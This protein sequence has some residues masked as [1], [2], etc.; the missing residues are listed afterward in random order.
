[1]L[2]R[3]GIDIGIEPDVI[4]PKRRSFHSPLTAFCLTIHKSYTQGLRSLDMYLP[5]SLGGIVVVVVVLMLLGV[6]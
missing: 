4:Q 2:Q 6:I 3:V 1:M 5:I